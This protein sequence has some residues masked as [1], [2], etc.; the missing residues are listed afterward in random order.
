MNKVAIKELKRLLRVLRE[1][2]GAA[3]CSP[4]MEARAEVRH[5]MRV[6]IRSRIKL[7]ENNE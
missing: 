3:V 7:L 4:V 6:E 2:P 5:K 1:Q